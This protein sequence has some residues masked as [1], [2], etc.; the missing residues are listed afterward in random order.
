MAFIIV[1]KNSSFDMSVCVCMECLV[2]KFIVVLVL[3]GFFPLRIDASHHHLDL[4]KLH[5]CI[6]LIFPLSVSG[7]QKK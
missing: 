4:A 5:F 1:S 3:Y 2:N 6:Y 7:S